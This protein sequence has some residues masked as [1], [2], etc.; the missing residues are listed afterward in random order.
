MHADVLGVLTDVQP[1]QA[2]SARNATVIRDITLKVD[3]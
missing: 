2:A 1:L 3:R